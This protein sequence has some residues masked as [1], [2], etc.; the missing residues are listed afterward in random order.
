[1]GRKVLHKFVAGEEEHEVLLGQV[2]ST[3]TVRVQH[4]TDAAGKVREELPVTASTALA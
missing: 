4:E 1:M 2:E 3:H